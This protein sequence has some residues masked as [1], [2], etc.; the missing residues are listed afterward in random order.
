MVK[1]GFIDVKTLLE[2][3]LTQCEERDNCLFE[4]SL[5]MK[6]REM[7]VN[8][9][10]ICQGKLKNVYFIVFFF[11]QHSFHVEHLENKGM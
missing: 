11:K 8:M 1:G 9:G 6:G 5:T 3:E 7:T 4:L 2:K 10:D